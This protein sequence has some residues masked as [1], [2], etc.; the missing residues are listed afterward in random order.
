VTRE[1]PGALEDQPLLALLELRVEV[2]A[3]VKGGPFGDC[4][5]GFDDRL[6]I[7]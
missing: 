2:E 1:L 6:L 7:L 4:C 5:Q 3:G